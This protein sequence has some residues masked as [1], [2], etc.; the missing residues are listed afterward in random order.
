MID[1]NDRAH[2]NRRSDLA[3]HA[4]CRLEA[5]K[6]VIPHFAEHHARY[7]KAYGHTLGILRSLRTEARQRER[8]E[9][10]ARHCATQRQRSAQRRASLALR[11]T[12]TTKT[13]KRTLLQRVLAFFSLS[14]TGTTR[15]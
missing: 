13:K 12:N 7:S 3:I 14:P 11:G 9:T 4:A 5:E 6:A 1:Q 2:R 15:S 8:A 10:S